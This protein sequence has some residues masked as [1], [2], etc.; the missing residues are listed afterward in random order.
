LKYFIEN[1]I[2]TR[3]Q[4][5][6]SRRRKIMTTATTTT[7]MRSSLT[8]TPER[9]NA[10]K[11][12]IQG[13]VYKIW[14][15]PDESDRTIFA[16]L[17]VDEETNEQ[18]A[19]HPARL[20][21][22]FLDGKVA[23]RPF[24]LLRGEH[25]QVNGYMVDYDRP[26]TLEAFIAKCQRRDLLEEQ[27]ELAKIAS[28]SVKRPM[29]CLIPTEK[30]S[31]DGL[32]KTEYHDL[33]WDHSNTALLEGVVVSTW[34]YAQ[35]KFIRLAVY[36][37]NTTVLQEKGMRPRRRPHYVTIQLTNGKIGE[38]EIELMG[39]RSRP[40]PN[41]IR[42]GDRIGVQGRFTQQPQWDNLRSFIIRSGQA[43]VLAKLPD[44]DRYSEIRFS[45]P[46]TVV[47]ALWFVQYT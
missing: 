43:A 2:S 32:P 29:T 4:F 33:V 3:T 30:D 41:A 1:Y 46:M 17:Q 45:S 35:H 23:G 14:P 37:R 47:E 8:Y 25:I 19:G 42:I 16:R 40:K 20:T 38:V 18:G 28:A 22:A 13:I 11:A 34:D 10:N 39:K 15:S 6:L 21:L 44:T 24:N 7:A 12:E 31:L 9:F 36:D 27:P 5:N 26:E